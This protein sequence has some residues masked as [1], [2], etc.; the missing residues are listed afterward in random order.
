MLYEGHHKKQVCTIHPLLNVSRYVPVFICHATI[1]LLKNMII[2]QTMYT[3]NVVTVTEIAG[4]V[5]YI[6]TPHQATVKMIGLK[7]MEVTY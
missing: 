7:Q 3:L 1:S 6:S 4:G 5:T 2:H